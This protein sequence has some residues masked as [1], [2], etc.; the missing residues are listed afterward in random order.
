MDEKQNGLQVRGCVR[1]EPLL[2][3][4]PRD[5]QKESGQEGIISGPIPLHLSPL[6]DKDVN[7]IV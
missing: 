4:L 6:R 1:L 5:D 7:P 3:A 2:G